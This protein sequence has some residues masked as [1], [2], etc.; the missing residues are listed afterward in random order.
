MPYDNDNNAFCVYKK[1]FLLIKE[2]YME[3]KESLPAF[4]ER[5]KKTKDAIT[6]EEMT[7]TSMIMPFFQMLGYEIFNPLEFI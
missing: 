1:F 5:I 3:L 2:V 6:N 4:V 7:K